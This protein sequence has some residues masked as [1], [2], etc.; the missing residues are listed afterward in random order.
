MSS[1]TTDTTGTTHTP[2]GPGSLR[3]N[4][5]NLPEP[6]DLGKSTFPRFSDQASG[7]THTA[8]S[9]ANH[10]SGC[11]QGGRPPQFS[12]PSCLTRGD[13]EDITRPP[14]PTQIHPHTPKNPANTGQTRPPKPKTTPKPP[15]QPPVKPVTPTKT[16][17]PGRQTPNP[18]T[19][20]EHSQPHTK[21]RQD[22]REGS[23]NTPRRERRTV[24]THPDVREG[25]SKTTTM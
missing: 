10:F 23:P 22:M 13:S 25:C 15:K 6:P 7:P 5:P 2:Q 4:F 17:R 3:S 24:Q 19:A 18:T 12:A 21:N 1:Q 14:A 16:P 8:R 9:K 11:Y 20:V